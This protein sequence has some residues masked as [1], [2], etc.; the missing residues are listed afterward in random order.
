MISPEELQDTEAREI[1]GQ[2]IV[3]QPTRQEVDHHNRT[4][5]PFRKWCPFC[6]SGK[7]RSGAHQRKSKSEEE[8]E[9]ETPIISTDYMGPNSRFLA[10]LVGP[11]EER[12]TSLP[13]LTG[14]SRR[15]KWCL[16]T[17]S[18]GRDTMHRQSR[19]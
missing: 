19:C 7:C 4:D 5:F 8:L 10:K 1:P 2:K 13:I 6:V 17:W 9:R 18:P 16:C 12:I 11:E 15:T 3:Y 14:I